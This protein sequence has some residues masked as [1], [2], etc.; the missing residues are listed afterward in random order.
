MPPW[1]WTRLPAADS[2][3]S[4][5]YCASSPSGCSPIRCDPRSSGGAAG[6][7]RVGDV[8]DRGWALV[9]EIGRL[10]T[11]N[12]RL[13]AEVARLREENARLQ[14]A[15]QEAQRLRSLMAVRQQSFRT[16]SA[17]VIGRDPSHW[18]NTLLIDRG[19]RDGVRRNDPV[20]TSEGLVGHVI[21]ASGGWARVLLVLDPR[22][23]IGV[24]V[25]R[26]RDAGV[27]EGQGQPMLR[28]KY[29]S[30]DAEIQPGDQVVTAGLGEIYPRGLVVGT[31][32]DVSR[33]EGDLFRE[34]LVR[35]A[36]DLNHL[37]EMVILVAEGSQAPR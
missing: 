29:L 36:A 31:V 21:E 3:S 9:T 24:L 20:V 11:E 13:A 10:R 25:G 2:S 37:E 17:R 27:A 6:L 5:S 19:P 18:F 28:V 30:R 1:Y 4:S 16:V 33:G 15:A 32:V 12:R 23:A 26:S 22:S 14:D 7:S 35:P 34:A 8:V